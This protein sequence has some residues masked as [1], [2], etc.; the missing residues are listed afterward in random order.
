M[1]IP[2]QGAHVSACPENV[3]GLFRPIHLVVIQIKIVFRLN[4]FVAELLF[5]LNCYCIVCSAD[6]S[7]LVYV[8]FI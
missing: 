1:L 7:V 6:L 5:V 2:R 3:L 8:Y 4:D